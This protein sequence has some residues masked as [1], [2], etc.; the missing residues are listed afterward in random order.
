MAD[1]PSRLAAALADRY[2][3]ERELGEGGMATVYLARDL[4]HDRQVAIK[5]LRPELAAVIGAERFLAE[6]RTTANLQHPHILPLHDSGEVDGTVFYVMP[7]VEGE[8]L[9]DRLDREHQL[10]VS[11]AVRM[12]IEVAGALDYA[13]RHGV[14]HR[15][16][17]PENILLHDGQ[18]LVADFGIALAVSRADG[19]TRMTE[20]GMSLG[21]PHYMSPE[22]AMGERE[23]TARSDVYA[24]GCVLYEMLLGEPPFTGP[25]PQAIIARVVTEDPRSLMAQ[26]KTIPPGVEAAVHTALQKLPADRFATAA[27]FAEA[28]QHPE[29]APAGARAPTSAPTKVPRWMWGVVAAAAAIGVVAGGMRHAPASADPGV[30]RATFRLGDSVLIRAIQN[31]LLA[32]SPDGRRVAFVGM[33]SGVTTTSLWIRNLNEPRA[34]MIAG[35]GTPG[36]PFFSPDGR[37]IGFTHRGGIMV[38]SVEGGTVRTVVD[39]GSTGFGASW[40]DD[41]YIYFANTAYGLSRVPAAG[42]AVEVV[43]HPD[44]ASKDLVQDFPDVLPG[45]RFAIVGIW[46]G[47]VATAKIGVVDLRTGKETA[48]ADGAYARY[49]APGYLAIGTTNGDLLTA[50]FDPARGVLTGPPVLA[51][52]DVDHDIASGTVQFAVSAAGT[53]IYTNGDAK[54]SRLVWRDRGGGEAVIDSVH[55]GVLTTVALS[56]DGTRAALSRTESGGSSV[57]IEQFGTGALT[58]LSVNE[59]DAD[60]AVWTPDGRSVAYL[61]T[62]DGHRRV[63]VRRADA[64]DTARALSPAGLDLDEVSFDPQRR[65]ILYRTFG[66]GP[67]SR[68]LLIARAGADSV[69]RPFLS[70]NVDHYAMTFSSDGNWLAY[71]SESSGHPEV[72]VRPF[73]NADSARFTVSVNGGV[74]PVWRRDGKELFYRSPR[75]ETFV[76]PTTIGRTF[77]HGV[78]KQLLEST[79]GVLGPY[80]RDYDVSA[81]GR[82]FL[83]VAGGDNGTREI[84]LVVNWR[85]ELEQLGRKP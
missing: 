7:F 82:R 37:A 27:E 14:I 32:I 31:E 8:S 39:T 2:R 5:V 63:W 12:A 76:V 75:G 67:G 11:D 40:A 51:V 54:N 20:T 52:S 47:N 17:K 79:G 41:G 84:S 24:L 56:P 1:A 73:P 35:T 38:T 59:A 46:R 26:R 6:I 81:D 25:T 61:A 70:S 9:R 28:L 85:Q 43:S 68:H 62:R 22:Q 33:A 15:D 21:T 13:H 50:P 60:R 72:V 80:F 49:V 55:A 42:G 78:P 30:I 34:R 65:Y 57:W 36:A 69:L 58:R 3:I 71:V 18:S 45:A 66:T 19:S 53:L 16:I 10:P 77:T 4:K 48:I 74:E 44:S 23:I 83:M 29:R 64:S